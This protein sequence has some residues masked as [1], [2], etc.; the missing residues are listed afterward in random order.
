[1]K[2][3][4][5]RNKIGRYHIR[6]SLSLTIRYT[7]LVILLLLLAA[8]FPARTFAQSS[9]RWLLIFDTSSSMRSRSKGTEDM[10]QDLL[11][12]GMHGRLH[13]GDTIGIW[14]FSD[15]LHAGEAP[16]Q[17]WSPEESQMIFRHTMQYLDNLRYGK[18]A[19]LTVALTNMYNVVD[20]S[21]FITV[22]LFSDGDQPVKGTPFDE[23]INMQYKE[24]YRQAKKNG[25]PMITVFQAK[26]GN[27][28]T[29]T[30]NFGPWPIDI[31]AVP[32]PT[33]KPLVEPQAAPTPPPQM[34]PPIIFDGRKSQSDAPQNT[35]PPANNTEPTPPVVTQ[36]TVTAAPAETPS[37]TQPATTPTTPPVVAETQPPPATPPPAAVAANNQPE[38]KPAAVPVTPPAANE[39]EPPPA[40]P[41]ETA[42]KP[43][44]AP[45]PV[46]TAVAAPNLLSSRNIAIASVAFAVF[47][48]GLLL[49]AARNARKTQSSLITRSLDREQR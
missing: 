7:S 34:G 4:E 29:N 1:M 9:N 31:P 37:A 46:E 20:S 14:T 49:M 32:S 13:H 28:T 42:S 43:T 19:D 16:L 44:A 21:D 3:E 6:A 39:S 22:I 15:A 33:P 10:M 48:C 23:A 47:V 41:A 18:S 24:D 26:H 11:S 45:P 36:P 38:S 2:N 35:A 17:V 27:F 12:T 8:L 30:V 5:R 25:M 40:A